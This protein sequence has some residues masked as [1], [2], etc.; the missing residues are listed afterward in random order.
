ML[1][2]HSSTI[3]SNSSMG[4][5]ELQTTGSSFLPLSTSDSNSEPSSFSAEKTSSPCSFRYRVFTPDRYFWPG[6]SAAFRLKPDGLS[7][8]NPGTLP[9]SNNK[10]SPFSVPRPTSR[11]ATPRPAVIF[12]SRRLWASQP[13][14]AS[15]PSISCRSSSS[16][17]MGDLTLVRLHQSDSS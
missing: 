4:M 11:T 2:W 14:W 17:N 3:M 13:H 7:S 15:W 10:F 1:R 5:R 16:G 9:S 8:M 6:V 12:M